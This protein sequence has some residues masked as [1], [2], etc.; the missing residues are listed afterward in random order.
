MFSYFDSLI[1]VTPIINKLSYQFRERWTNAAVTYNYKH[2][3]AY[4][5]FNVCIQFTREQSK[6]RN[7]LS[8][9]FETSSYREK[10]I[11]TGIRSRKKDHNLY[12]TLNMDPEVLHK[13]VSQIVSTEQRC[14]I[15][16]TRHSLNNC[17]KFRSNLFQNGLKF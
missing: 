11:H 3:V 13:S 6:I 7:N 16:N 17:R 12:E 9:S 1:G 14:P 10:P 4:L 2:D 5:H 8:F 15:H